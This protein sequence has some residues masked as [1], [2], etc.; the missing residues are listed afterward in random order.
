MLDQD[1]THPWDPGRFAG[2]PRVPETGLDPNHHPVHPPGTWESALTCMAAGYRPTPED[3]RALEHWTKDLT[4]TQRREYLTRQRAARLRIHAA[5]RK[6]LARREVVA[7]SALERRIHAELAGEFSHPVICHALT[8]L[9]TLT[10]LDAEGSLHQATG[11]SI[12]RQ[13]YHLLGKHVHYFSRSRKAL[14]DHP[15]KAVAAR[16]AV[17]LSSGEQGK[18]FRFTT[19]TARAANA[20]R[21]EKQ[22]I[23]RTQRLDYQRKAKAA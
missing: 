19:E 8:S 7:L 3:V 15:A 22:R 17:G 20:A 4:P 5:A 9:T 2:L 6:V 21:W 23:R 13:H 16:Q 11:V 10:M 18:G 12:Y 1:V 14:E